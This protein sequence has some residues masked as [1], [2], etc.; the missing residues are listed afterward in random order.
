METTRNTMMA[1]LALPM[2]PPYHPAARNKWALYVFYIAGPAV[3]NN[4]PANRDGAPIQ[5]MRGWK[6]DE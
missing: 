1:G 6:W 4:G 2:L 5:Y 3:A